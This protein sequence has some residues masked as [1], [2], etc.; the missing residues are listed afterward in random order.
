MCHAGARPFVLSVEGEERRCGEGG[1]GRRENHAGGLR[2]LRPAP[3]PALLHSVPDARQRHGG[4][5][6]GAGGLPAVEAGL[7]GRGAV[8]EGLPVGGGHE[9][10]HRPAQVRAGAAGGV[11]G[12]VATGAA[13]GRAGAGRRRDRRPRRLALDG[14]PR[15]AGE[16]H[17]GGA[18][19]LPVARGL[20]LRVRGDSRDRRQE[21]GQLPTDLPP[22]Q[23][24]RG[25]PAAPLRAL[26]GAGGTPYEEVS[27]GLRRRRHGRPA[28]GALGRRHPVV[29]RRGKDPRGAQPGPRRGQRG[30]P[31]PRNAP[32]GPAGSRGQ[33]GP[34][35]RQPRPGRLLR[36]RQAPERDDL[37]V[38]GGSDLGDPAR[39]Q[40]GEAGGRAPI[41]SGEGGR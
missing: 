12:P 17:A 18:G 30:P 13:A 10:V 31:S 24:L 4:G 16:P 28:G 38:L 35:Q 11:R 3:A 33:A 6:R 1:S 14:L 7:G 8:G 40:P 41:V 32:Q 23:G 5:G 26:T 15:L 21:R 25:G 20:R 22:R 27:G 39:G 37:R 29:R 2:G 36:R 34:D 19:R 9:V